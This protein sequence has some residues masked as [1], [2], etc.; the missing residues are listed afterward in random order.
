[1]GGLRS[2]EMR[3]GIHMRLWHPWSGRMMG[4][5]LARSPLRMRLGSIENEGSQ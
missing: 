1:M 2:V 4:R 3:R 5:S